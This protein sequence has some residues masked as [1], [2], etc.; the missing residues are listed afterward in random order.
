MSEPATDP[1]DRTERRL[2][3]AAVVVGAFVLLYGVVVAQQILAAIVL[4]VWLVVVYLL[5]RF[6]RAH[7]RLADAATRVA[8]AETAGALSTGRERE[9]RAT[10]RNPTDGSV[11]SAE[12]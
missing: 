6:V 12:E 1:D 8:D 9:E 3:F 4:L 10:A 11:D 7:E 5:W 2:K